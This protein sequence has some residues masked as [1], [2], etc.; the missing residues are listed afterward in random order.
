MASVT[1]VANSATVTVT[2][3][4]HGYVAGNTY[5]LLVPVTVGGL[6]LPI[7]NYLVQKVLSPNTFIILAKTQAPAAA[8]VPINGGQARLVYSFGVGPILPATGFGH[9]R[10]RRRP[11]RRRRRAGLPGQRRAD[12]RHRLDAR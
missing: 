2:L 10:L 1:T 3:P 12:Q 11:V 5:P 4:N 9:R 8:T 7:G 6:T